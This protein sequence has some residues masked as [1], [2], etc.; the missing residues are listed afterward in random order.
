MTSDGPPN[1]EQ[2]PRET[3]PLEESR[4]AA[5]K[6][7][8]VWETWNLDKTDNPKRHLCS[9]KAY[10]FSTYHEASCWT[11]ASTSTRLTTQPNSLLFRCLFL[12]SSSLLV[13][14]RFLCASN[15]KD[16][17]SFCKSSPTNHRPANPAIPRRFP[18]SGTATLFGLIPQG[19]TA[20]RH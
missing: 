18:R 15:K 20:H 14:R 6:K 13:G 8:S 12:S 17:H 1:I 11:T 4:A 7:E 16:S 19:P 9:D 5:T 3:G 10:Y 2:R